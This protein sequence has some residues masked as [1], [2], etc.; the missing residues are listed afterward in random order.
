MSP[1]IA[2]LRDACSA[3]HCVDLG[4]GRGHLPIV[5][6]LEYS[7][8]SLAVDCDIVALDGGKKRDKLIQV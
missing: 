7:V 2:S 4:G 6:D 5:L 3:T 8:P 1:L